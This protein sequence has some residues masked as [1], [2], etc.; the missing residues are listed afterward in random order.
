MPSGGSGR[1][2]IW[3]EGRRGRAKEKGG[4]AKEKGGRAK[5]AGGREGGWGK[6]EEGGIWV[7]YGVHTDNSSEHLR[8][9]PPHYPHPV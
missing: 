5:E 7:R 1:E 3:G 8:A 4:R 6:R 9:I 2:K